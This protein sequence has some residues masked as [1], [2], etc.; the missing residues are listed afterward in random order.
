MTRRSPL[1]RKLGRDLMALRSQALAVALVLACGIGILV[2][3]LGMRTSLQGARDQYYQRQAMADLQVQAVRAP[4]RLHESLSRLPGVQAI[5]LRVVATAILELP[6]MVEPAASRLISLPTLNQANVNRPLLVA[7]RWPDANRH[8]EVLL[9]EAFAEANQLHAGD[10]LPATVRGR[11]ETLRIVGIANSPEFVFISAPGELFPQPGRYAVL[12]MPETALAKAAGMEGAF[13]DAVFRLGHPVDQAGLR[14]AIDTL[15]KPYG[16]RGTFGQDRMV[17]AR[18][19]NDELAQLSAMVATLTPI[20]LVVGAFLLN[21]TLTRLVTAERANIGLLKAFGYSDA[22]IGWHYSQTALILAAMGIIFGLG[23]GHL[24]G[25]WMG[26]IY[27]SFYRLPSLPFHASPE[28][29][30]LA[31]L[32]GVLAALT[33]AL[34]AVRQ[35]TRLPPATA[36]APP[37]PPSFHRSGGW[38]SMLVRRLDPLTRIILRRLWGYPRRSLSTLI[39]VALA[40]SVLVVSQHFPAATNKLLDVTF[41]LA[42]QHHATLTL[43]EANGPAALHAIA[44]LPGVSAVEPFR[45]MEVRYYHQGK[46]AREALIGLPADPRLER[47]LDNG[48]HPLSLREDGI[49]LSRNL[50]KQLAVKP[51]DRIKIEATDGL[52][53]R[54]QVTVIQVADLWVGATGYMALSA[55][56]QALGEPHR[57]NGAY[58]RYDSRQHAALNRAVRNSP[59]IASISFTSQAEASMRQTFSQGAGFMATLFLT[60]AGLMSAGIAYATAQVTFAEQQRDLA[61]L[62]VLGFSQ[63]E[64]SYVLLGELAL[65]STLAVPFGLW[66]GYGFA[67]WLMRSLSN[68]LFTIPMVVDPAAYVESAAFVLI[69]ILLSALWVRRRV[70]RLDLVASLKY[71]E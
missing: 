50:A 4:K 12:W 8:D 3:G 29:W 48:E 33:G 14:Q 71:R 26:S 23:L 53:R 56:G 22:A 69:I 2:M 28:L 13:N 58:L 49:V 64:A 44:R 30:V 19:L 43:I 65:L 63:R 45:A 5:E 38:L 42:K 9:N 18:F 55:L 41:R 15:M 11:R 66:L 10:V 40:L 6:T 16:G 36:L 47:L 21:V 46:T 52:R 61:T 59:A 32:V 20:F 25:E 70:D 1:T 57:I 39:G 17:S 27:R 34:S 68:E 60:F 67:W 24:F 31:A 7:G 35:A 62:Q 54:T 51:G 37:A